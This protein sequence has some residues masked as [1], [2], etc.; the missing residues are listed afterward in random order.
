VSL[1]FLSP[2]A[3]DP[4]AVARSPMER[5]AKDA[6][7]RFEARNGW[8]VAVEY[9]DQD[10]FTQTVAWADMSHLRKLELQGEAVPG[11]LGEA[12]REGDAWICQ[13]TPTRALLIGGEHTAPS[14]AIDV[15][16]CYAAL[17]IFGPL[18]REVI[19]RFC[20]L[21]LRPQVAPP[22]SFRPGSIARQP[23]MIVVEDTDRFLLLFGWAVGEY[24]WTVV[25]DAARS[26]DG[27][28]Y[29][30]AALKT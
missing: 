13:L 21:D 16:T 23:G 5:R 27:G 2:T 7:A 18:A 17:T 22:G 11:E 8:N 29:G 19:A 25:E 4:T 3:A 12:K 28:P 20:A 6:G 1:T 9:P 15:T 26:L 10:R 24:V 14:E 30:S